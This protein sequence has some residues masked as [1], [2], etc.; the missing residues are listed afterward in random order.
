LVQIIGLLRVLE[1]VLLLCVVGMDHDDFPLSLEPPC[2]VATAL[3]KAHFVGGGLG[4]RRKRSICGK[5][6]G[7]FAATLAPNWLETNK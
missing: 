1:S 6:D 2:P 5:R 3:W 7:G 4:R